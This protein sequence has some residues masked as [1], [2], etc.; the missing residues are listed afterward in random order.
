MIFAGTAAP[1]RLKLLV[2]SLL[3]AV[4]T[5]TT[6]PAPTQAQPS[7]AQLTGRI[8]QL[9]NE[10]DLAN[11]EL[12]KLLQHP[13]AAVRERA[14]LALGRIGDRRSTQALVASLKSDQNERVRLMS[15]FA[16][17]EIE[18]N[19]AIEALMLTLDNSTERLEVRARAVE[20]LG[21]ITSQASIESSVSERV[22]QRILKGLPTTETRLAG[23][24]ELMA[25]LS[26]SALMRLRSPT[27]IDPL[28]RQLKSD[29]AN[30]RAQ[31]A[32]ALLRL[33]RPTGS[34]FPALLEAVA[35]ESDVV[36]ANVARALGATS[37]RKAF[38]PL[39]Q[40]LLDSNERVRVSA[41]RGLAAL[42]DAGGRAFVEI[43]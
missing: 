1:F 41:V 23:D 19:Q 36:R 14:A 31:A 21:K 15:A 4:F 34:T 22:S 8:V 29:A 32:N 42:G 12:E 24:E 18:D 28:A 27:A 30:V 3:L 37:D 2:S 17:G 26:I 43:R 39:T 16:L 10:R 6:F 33:R 13:R 11:G 38:E 20:A 40:M 9:E 7:L 5:L 25:L 35:D